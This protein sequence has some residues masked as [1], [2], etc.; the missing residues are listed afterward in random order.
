MVGIAAG[1]LELS[2]DCVPGWID[3]A[4]KT[5]TASGESGLG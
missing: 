2:V 3:E 1:T 5:W 4:T